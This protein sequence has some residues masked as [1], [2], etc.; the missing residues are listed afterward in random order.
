MT[1]CTLFFPFLQAFPSMISSSIF[2]KTMKKNNIKDGSQHTS[3]RHPA[4]PP[5]TKDTKDFDSSLSS[6]YKGNG[7][8]KE[9]GKKKISVEQYLHQP[10][11][12]RGL[13]QE[14]KTLA[15]TTSTITATTD[16]ILHDIG[17]DATRE[18]NYNGQQK[19]LK[20]ENYIRGQKSKAES[21][22][23]LVG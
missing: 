11:M 1:Q 9:V 16:E 19:Y 14:A 5:I 22:T 4:A 8:K 20:N 15:L 12:I 3:S 10:K 18:N 2:K 17:G 23:W 7:N 6:L 13:I 21:L